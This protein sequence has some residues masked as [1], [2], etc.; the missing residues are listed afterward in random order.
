LEAADGGTI[1]LGRMQTNEAWPRVLSRGLHGHVGFVFQ[2][3]HLLPDLTALENVALPLMIARL[4]SARS[5]RQA[6]TALEEIGLGNRL[7]HRIGY[8][9][10][11]EQQ[12]VAVARA[13]VTRPRLLLADEPTG[14]V[15]AD[16]GDGIGALLVNY[17]R[18][19]R[20]V[21]VIATHN[22]RLAR[23]CDRILVLRDG[24]VG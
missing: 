19:E 20:V 15:D 1:Q 7:S 6:A 4:G 24:I 12:R 18:A 11:G 14:N 17:C 2:F 13:L 5:L 10:G 3:H 21:G 23:L 9:S 8:L 16:I 22:E